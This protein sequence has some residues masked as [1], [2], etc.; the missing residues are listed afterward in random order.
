[1]KHGILHFIQRLLVFS[2]GGFW[3][4]RGISAVIWLVGAGFKRCHCS[5]VVRTL[6]ANLWT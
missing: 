5:K 3:R 4:A 2:V 6:D 1:M